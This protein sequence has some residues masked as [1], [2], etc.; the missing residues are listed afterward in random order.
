MPKYS[1]KAIKRLKGLLDTT[2][3]QE[4]R[5][6]LSLDA[7]W[8]KGYVTGIRNCINILETETR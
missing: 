5:K 3:E 2:V 8:N 6:E 4:A 7:S 1:N